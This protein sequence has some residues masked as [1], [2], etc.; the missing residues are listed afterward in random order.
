VSKQ[1]SYTMV[2]RVHTFSFWQYAISFVVTLQNF[3]NKHTID[4][5]K[6]TKEI[7]KRKRAKL[8]DVKL[9]QARAFFVL[10]IYQLQLQDSRLNEASKYLTRS[11]ESTHSGQFGS[12]KK[13]LKKLNTHQLQV[14]P[15]V[16]LT[17]PRVYLLGDRTPK[18][19]PLQVPQG[20]LQCLSACFTERF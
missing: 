4:L 6:C 10:A 16:D 1:P 3:T 17:L 19:P 2:H 15:Q 18:K 13:G 5:G 8:R 20:C 14:I 7:R 9:A 12:F 11:L